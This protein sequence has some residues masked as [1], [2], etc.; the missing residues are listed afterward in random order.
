MDDNFLSMRVS[1]NFVEIHDLY[2]N[3]TRVE[4][5]EN[6][7]AVVHEITLRTNEVEFWEMIKKTADKIK[8]DS[9][10]GVLQQGFAKVSHDLEYL[11]KAQRNLESA[12]QE[13]GKHE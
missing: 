4:H 12:F 3:L 6:H 1:K 8:A 11:I 9:K 5:F 7:P 10:Q 2:I 13:A